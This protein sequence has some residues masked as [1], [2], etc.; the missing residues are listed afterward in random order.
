MDNE[1]RLRRAATFNEIA[2]LYD[3]GRREIPETVLN[4]LF[5]QTGV[6]PAHAEVLELGCGTGQATLP[7]AR[8]GCRI[9]ALEMG[10]N[11]AEIARRKTSVFRDV[12]VHNTRF[13]DWKAADRT[14]DLVFATN[15]WHWFD[16]ASRS[17]RAA[18]ALRPGGFLAFT[19]VHHVFPEGYDPIFLEIQSC[20][21]EAGLARLTWPPPALGEI[22]D[23]RAELEHCGYFDVIKVLRRL[24]T[25]DFS[26]DEYIALMATAS[27]H[28]LMD[29]AKRD[30]LFAE[31]RRLIDARPGQRVRKHNLTIL[32]IAR[33]T[34]SQ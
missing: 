18:A 11:L 20:Y 21:E 8:R 1:T 24:E 6:N 16:P 32:H 4:D 15:A 26:A 10:V 13:E 27:D 12:Q 30:W 14:F 9:V 34:A 25:E 17:T 31:M 33:K 22:E 5:S 2:E 3:R 23:S 19:K 29:P 7:L 28:R